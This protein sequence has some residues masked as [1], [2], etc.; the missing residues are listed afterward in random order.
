[1]SPRELRYCQTRGFHVVSD[2][3]PCR[4]SQQR[5]GQSASATDTRRSLC[6]PPGSRHPMGLQGGAPRWQSSPHS[7]LAALTP[8]AYCKRI[9][10]AST[11]RRGGQRVGNAHAR[12]RFSFLRRVLRV[13]THQRLGGVVP[14]YGAELRAAIPIS[15][16]IY[17]AFRGG[18]PCDG[19][20]R[21]GRGVVC[22][23]ANAAPTGPLLTF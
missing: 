12:E 7:C 19:P 20:D 10:P 11:P 22:R 9:T 15:P 14:R 23:L 1:M 5:L 4:R 18:G 16:E 8:W 3:L 13:L 2:T 6:V 17:P 21:R